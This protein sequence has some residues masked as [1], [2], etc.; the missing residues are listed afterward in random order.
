MNIQ[1]YDYNDGLYAFAQYF[2]A[3]SLDIGNSILIS[4]LNKFYQKEFLES[5]IWS[6]YRK[7]YSVEQKDV[8]NAELKKRMITDF[9]NVFSETA[10]LEYFKFQPQKMGLKEIFVVHGFARIICDSN[11]WDRVHS[12][13]VCLKK[14]EDGDLKR[15]NNNIQFNLHGNYQI[16]G[17]FEPQ[18]H[19]FQKLDLNHLPDF[20]TL[21][22]LSI[23][24]TLKVNN[25]INTN[26]KNFHLI[27]ELTLA[28][29]NIYLPALTPEIS[30]FTGLK[31]ISI[32]LGLKKLPD[33]MAN[34]KN[35]SIIDLQHN[36][37]EEFPLVL[38]NLS[39]LMAIN[40]SHNKIKTFPTEITNLTKLKRL[41]LKN[42]CI[43]SIPDFLSSLKLDSLNLEKNPINRTIL[44][45]N[46]AAKKI[47]LAETAAE[48]EKE[49]LSLKK[50]NE[51]KTFNLLKDQRANF[52]YHYDFYNNQKIKLEQ[53]IY[54]S[55]QQQVMQQIVL[56]HQIFKPCEFEIKKAHLQ[57]LQAN[58]I[59]KLMELYKIKN[60]IDQGKNYRTINN[61]SEP[62]SQKIL[63]QMLDELKDQQIELIT[64]LQ[65]IQQ[66]QHQHR[67][68]LNN[69]RNRMF[70][71][72]Q[73][74]LDIIKQ[75][76]LEKEDS[77]SMDE[78]VK[79]QLDV[80]RTEKRNNSFDEDD[81][82]QSDLKKPRH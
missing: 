60:S 20:E 49:Q 19:E 70:Q 37:L 57:Q 62:L 5:S 53:S 68:E 11:I 50:A 35:L 55:L 15:D 4:S 61:S 43:I 1:E 40:L 23:N 13:L 51:K 45:V 17:L 16:N 26:K 14:N 56:Q 67:I 63:K 8:S 31:K 38:T 21:N 46:M 44:P 59:N 65:Q 28:N 64:L 47:F 58:Q 66:L 6:E 41:T 78:D 80:V 25:W 3:S 2:W 79:E 42:N 22:K 18:K 69:L 10:P 72:I 73:A 30:L 52:K 81:S 48:Q 32:S 36:L 82:D 24:S 75:K 77:I 9:T 54:G 29:S 27:T 39:K 71:Q 12:R 7:I 74:S 34:L 33:G 76:N